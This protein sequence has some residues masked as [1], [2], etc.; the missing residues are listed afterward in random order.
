VALLLGE[1]GFTAFALVGGFDA[2]RDAGY[3]LEPLPASAE[4]NGA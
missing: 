4:V 2:W 3:P 1:R